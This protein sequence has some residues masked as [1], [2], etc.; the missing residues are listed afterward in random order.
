MIFSC[1]DC[2]WLSRCS[3]KPR[4]SARISNFGPSNYVTSIC[5]LL[6]FF[7][8]FRDTSKRV[9]KSKCFVS[10]QKKAWTRGWECSRSYFLQKAVWLH[11]FI[12]PLDHLC[13]TQRQLCRKSKLFLRLYFFFFFNTFFPRFLIFSSFVCDVHLINYSSSRIELLHI[14]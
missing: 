13:R 3:R 14:T 1:C 8:L 12:P 6:C 7:F 9:P 4:R 11:Q 2:E 10:R 5:R